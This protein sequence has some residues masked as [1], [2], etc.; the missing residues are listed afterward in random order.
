VIAVDTN[1]IV[2][3]VTRDDPLQTPRAIRCIGEGVYVADDVLMESEWVLRGTY[4]WPRQAVNQ[5][6]REFIG[7][8]P[9]HVRSAADL[10]WALQRHAAGADFAD[11]LHLLSAR[12]FSG[13]ASFEKQLARRAGPQAPTKV[14]LL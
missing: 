8:E 9:V 7:L 14:I 4:G 6:L 5:A 11:M 12:D 13:F 1:V 2:R 10:A 3:F